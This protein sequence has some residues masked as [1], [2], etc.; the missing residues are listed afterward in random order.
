MSNSRI[1]GIEQ[2]EQ[3]LRTLEAYGYDTVPVWAEHNEWLHR[4]DDHPITDHDSTWATR[5]EKPGSIDDHFVQILKKPVYGDD[6]S[7]GPV[8]WVETREYAPELLTSANAFEDRQFELTPGQRDTLREQHGL[9]PAKTIILSNVV[10]FPGTNVLRHFTIKSG[11]HI[12]P[13]RRKHVL[14]EAV[15]SAAKFFE[16]SAARDK[17]REEAAVTSD[18]KAVKKGAA[19][20]TARGAAM[21]YFE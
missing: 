21:K 13:R 4:L 2:I 9:T 16:T 6:R 17:E 8:S 18:I 12:D 7:L 14:V 1:N 11:E 5:N 19:P 15:V 3:A 10:T 20:K